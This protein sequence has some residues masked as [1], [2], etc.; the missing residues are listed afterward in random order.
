MDALESRHGDMG[1]IMKFLLSLFLLVALPVFGAVPSYQA[2]RGAGG[3]IIVS[4]PP[5]GTIVIDGS[6]VVASGTNSSIQISTNNT[7]AS[8]MA[9]NVNFTAGNNTVLRGTNI[10]STAH[11]NYGVESNLTFTTT[12]GVTWRLGSFGADSVTHGTQFGFWDVTQD[13]LGFWFN[14]SSEWQFNN[15]IYAPDATFALLPGSGSILAVDA[16]GTTFRTNITGIGSITWYANSVFVSTNGN[17]ATG[18]RGRIDLPFLTPVAAKV[19][20]VAGDTIFVNRGNYPNCTNLFKNLVNW[21]G[22][23][24]TLSHTNRTNDTGV[25]IFDDRFSGTVTSKISGFSFMH[26]LGVG[27]TNDSGVACCTPTNTLGT[28]V[29]TNARSAVDFTFDRIDY[30]E[31]GSSPNGAAL[32][33]MDGTNCFI[34]GNQILDMNL[35]TDVVVGTDEVGADVIATSVATGVFWRRGEHHVKVGRIESKRYSVWPSATATDAGNLWLA[36]D[37]I[38]GKF[39]ADANSTNNWKVWVRANEMR[40]NETNNLQ[41]MVEILGSGKYY[42]Q[43]IGKIGTERAGDT[44][45]SVQGAAVV[46]LGAQKLSAPEQWLDVG[47]GATV[48]AN[49]L[50]FEDTGAITNGINVTGGFLNLRGNKATVTNATGTA[51]H[52]S[53]GGLSI[54]GLRFSTTNSIGPPVVIRTNGAVLA[55]CTFIAKPGVWSLH[56]D[57]A[58][59]VN[60]QGCWGNTGETNLSYLVGPWTVDSNVR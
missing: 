19:V 12:A 26:S 40:V 60:V 7:A 43:D 3:I 10:G 33:L 51:V 39:Y 52:F 6:G 45:F 58:R 56:S 18:T 5:T 9:T 4:N 2:F 13:E 53:S 16:G 11:I 8:V 36:S 31:L 37:Y 42:F 27:H 24:A 20:A 29:L 22:Y 59:T 35:T 38:F 41:G 47:L 34:D 44:A 57:T 49:V 17:D 21:H 54:Q 48:T 1:L 14:G 55:N 25:G 46:W 30:Q 28:F 23:G 15:R 32:Y 50:E